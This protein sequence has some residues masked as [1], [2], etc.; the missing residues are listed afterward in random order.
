VQ[1]LVLLASGYVFYAWWDW[2]FLGLILLSTLVDYL[3]AHALDKAGSLTRRRALLAISIGVNLGVLGIFKYLDFFIESFAALSASFG[4]AVNPGSLGLILPV[5]ISFY[6]FQ[7]LGYTIDVY[8]GRERPSDDL[9]AFATYVSFFPQLVAGP[10]ER[11]GNLLPQL[12]EPKTRF[13]AFWAREGLGLIL[14]GLFQKV[15]IADTCARVADQIFA[16]PVGHGPIALLLGVVCFA[17]QIYGDFAGYSLVAIGSARLFGIRLM[18]NFRTPYFARDIAEFWRRWHISLST[19]FRDYVFIPLGGSRGR[20]RRIARNVVVTFTLSGLWHGASWTFVIWGLLCS[21]FYLPSIWSERRAITETP[22]QGRMFPSADELG[23]MAGT[24]AMVCL[25]WVFFRA[26]DPAT[27]VR[28]LTGLLSFDL[29]AGLGLLDIRTNGAAR[30]VCW[31]IPLFVG[32]E[33]WRRD[34]PDPVP[35]NH[36]PVWARVPATYLLAI[37]IFLSMGDPRAFIYFQF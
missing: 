18:T 12:R 17:F 26:P 11:P 27:A 4:L 20:R 31:L 19:W 22:A 23:A 36:L 24:F 28:Y 13:E 15:V 7:T 2:R 35:F 25:A 37:P 10:I 33:W 16:D 32:V 8:R 29:T 30:T 14:W 34:H 5:G 9:I 6:T 3:V 1:N 21:L